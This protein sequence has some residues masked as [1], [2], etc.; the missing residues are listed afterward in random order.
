MGLCDIDPDGV[1]GAT[2]DSAAGG[3]YNI[4]NLMAGDT[5]RISTGPLALDGVS[6]N[7]RDFSILYGF[8]DQL[9]ATPLLELLYEPDEYVTEYDTD[10]CWI[11]TPDARM[12]VVGDRIEIL[13]LPAFTELLR[14]GAFIYSIRATNL[15]TGF[16]GT[17]TEG[18]VLVRYSPTSPHRDIPYKTLAEVEAPEE[19]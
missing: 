14:R 8:S 13:L 9:F 5:L 3:K 7:V 11:I 16:T 2:G 18:H 19:S 17:L 6:I 12:R 15:E 4:A 10:T 1:N